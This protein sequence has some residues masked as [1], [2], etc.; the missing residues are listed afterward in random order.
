VDKTNFLTEVHAKTLTPANIKAAF[1]KTGI[2]PFNPNVV[3]TDMMALSQTTSTHATVPI[4]QS[5]PIKMMSEMVL[6]YINY[7]RIVMS[8]SNS[9]DAEDLPGLLLTPFFVQSAVDEL[10]STS[11]LFLVSSSL[12]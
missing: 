6:D 1:C 2:I 12:I 3:I 9:T 11:A 10:S 4:Q 8:S 5:G 7:Q